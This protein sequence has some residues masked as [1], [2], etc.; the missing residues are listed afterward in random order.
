MKTARI[1][2]NFGLI[3]QNQT[4]LY[5]YILIFYLFIISMI[6]CINLL[7][8]SFKFFNT[9]NSFCLIY[10]FFTI[11]YVSNIIDYCHVL[12]L[13]FSI[14]Y[15]IFS[16]NLLLYHVFIILILTIFFFLFL[17]KKFTNCN[18]D[19]QKPNRNVSYF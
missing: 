6:Y 15:I 12:I 7:F 14:L 8:V 17:Y 4:K 2:S 3:F 11:S 5:T 10:V 13:I 18:L 1:E 9:T 19:I 16:L